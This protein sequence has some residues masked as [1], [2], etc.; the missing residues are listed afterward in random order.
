MAKA[1]IILG[2]L[3]KKVLSNNAIAVPIP[4]YIGLFIID[5]TEVINDDGSISFDLIR[6]YGDQG[7]DGIDFQ[8]SRLTTGKNYEL[9]LDFQQFEGGWMSGYG[10]GWKLKTTKST[11]YTDYSTYPANL[12]RDMSVQHISTTFTATQENMYLA[13]NLC[14]L[15]DTAVNKIH[16]TNYNVVEV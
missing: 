6:P 3:G 2:D 15:Q 16:I 14:S 13:F 4:Y 5:G 11:G 12:N 10:F 1:Q 7:Y 9:S 8:I